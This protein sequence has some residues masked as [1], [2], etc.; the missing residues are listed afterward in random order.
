V[1]VDVQELV[2]SYDEKVRG[3]RT[4]TLKELHH[5]LTEQLK[6]RPRDEVLR[7]LQRIRE[8]FREQGREDMEDIVLDGMDMLTG[9]TGAAGARV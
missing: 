7:E 8:S 2:S 5:V 9:W 4:D 1:A 6:A 3:V